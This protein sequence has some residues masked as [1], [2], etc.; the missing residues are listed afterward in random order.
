LAIAKSA[1]IWNLAAS[2]GEEFEILSR[3]SGR[4]QAYQ[5][6]RAQ[7]SPHRVL[8]KRKPMTHGKKLEQKF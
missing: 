2:I 5:R 3:S 8:P 6:A 7:F 4:A 1:P